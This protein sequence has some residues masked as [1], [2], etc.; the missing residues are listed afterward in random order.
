V[1]LDTGSVAPLSDAEPL[2]GGHG[3]SPGALGVESDS[4]ASVGPPRARPS[5]PL[6]R[7][8]LAPLEPAELLYEKLQEPTDESPILYRERAYLVDTLQTDDDLEEHLEAELSRI[9][10]DWRHRDAS[11][12]VQLSL[13]DHRF[14][15]EPTFP[16]IATLS[17]KDWQGRSEIWVRGVRRSTLPPGVPVSM[18]PAIP[19]APGAAGVALG[20][21]SLEPPA[22]LDLDADVLDLDAELLDEF[23]ADERAFHSGD[24]FDDDARDDAARQLAGRF[25]VGADAAGDPARPASV[26]PPSAESA[27][28]P[29]PLVARPEAE[30]KSSPQSARQSVLPDANESEVESQAAA[31]EASEAA[32]DSGP[33]WQSP[34][35]SGEYLIPLPDELLAPSSQ[36]VLASEELIGALFERMHELAYATS[37]AAGADFV[38]ATLV[39][40]IPCEGV[41][42]HVFDAEADEFVVL[43]A[44]G[45]KS[46]EVLGRRM[47]AGRSHLREVLRGGAALE[48]GPSDVGRSL[49]QWP[50]LGVSPRHVVASPVQRDSRS[51]GAIELCRGAER[52]AFNPGQV[53]ALEY[54]CEQFADFVA[55]RPIELVRASLFPPRP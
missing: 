36:R 48:L 45:P 22:M 27:S 2:S 6:P 7:L 17:W 12:F 4:T 30:L 51:L 23:D 38:L 1:S 43:R 21:G 49:G 15:G 34:D 31:D 18:P 52:G 46:K 5:K 54:V 37:V 25:P 26:A 42:M 53:S 10:R 55:D 8:M 14:A 9:R 19:R 20:R 16:P 28:E 11:Q 50:A 32:P 24:A 33:G 41:L 47:A 40:N 29:I 39:E 35:R 3:S 13:F 44:S